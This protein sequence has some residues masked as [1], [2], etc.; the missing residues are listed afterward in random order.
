M[1]LVSLVFLI[2]SIAVAGVVLMRV[3]V[4]GESSV[5][6]VSSARAELLVGSDA[7]GRRV[8]MGGVAERVVVLDASGLEILL[9]LGVEPMLR[10]PFMG[11][12]PEH[13][14]GIEE[15]SY[16]H[17]A[18]PD[19]EQLILA[20][21]DL[22]VLS[23]TFARFAGVIEGVV[24]AE[25]LTIEVRSVEDAARWARELGRLTGA[26][27]RGEEVAAEM[28]AA[29][30]EQGL[31]EG[32]GG[33]RVMAL[34]GAPNAYFEVTEGSYIGDLVR[35]AGGELV[36]SGAPEHGVY[37]GLAPL[38]LEG[39]IAADPEV[40]LLMGHG[41][42]SSLPDDAAWRSLRAVRD[43]RVVELPERLFVLAPG[44]EVGRAYALM[45]DALFGEVAAGG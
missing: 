10:P 41:A 36:T 27:E 34:L 11:E 26:A 4:R 22:V 20:S 15:L 35:R 18:G 17:A 2:G 12:T 16:S 39:L 45:R 40:I 43:G 3:A 31:D 25:M 14:K 29:A 33:P 7:S 8:E 6:E 23:P 24:D 37:Q 21:P 38:S 32:T 42:A 1:R 5:D 44:A 28:L 19:V 9:A 13:W 30:P